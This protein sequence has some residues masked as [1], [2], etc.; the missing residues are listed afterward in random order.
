MPLVDGQ[1]LS[2]VYPLVNEWSS[3]LQ[4][5]SNCGILMIPVYVTWA[6]VRHFEGPEL[7]ALFVGMTL[8]PAGLTS[9]MEWSSAVADGTASY[10]NFA[11]LRIPQ[12]GFQGQILVGILAGV[13]LVILEKT[14]AK[15]ISKNAY[16]FVVPLVSVVTT[17]ILVYFVVGPIARVIE[18]GLVAAVDFLLRRPSMQYVGGALMGMLH[19][20]MMLFGL[21]LAMVPI[22]LQQVA[23]GNGS[24]LWP[25]TVCSVL[26]AGGAALAVFFLTKDEERKEAARQGILITLGL[27]SVEPAL[28]GVCSKDRCAFIG[29]MLAAGLA[30]FLSRVFGCTSTTFGLNGFFSFLTLPLEQWGYYAIVLAVAV[31][32]SFLFTLLLW[33][34]RARLQKK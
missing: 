11:L 27:G 14:L 16:S 5:I 33:T 10:W 31:G 15:H 12:A 23:S 21:H 19:L 30:G 1:S 18:S 7:L 32:G 8:V 24:P 25:I 20:P 9:G 13:I 22:N 4:I 3:F 26:S 28:F 17:C 34:A 2:A 29:A 6:T